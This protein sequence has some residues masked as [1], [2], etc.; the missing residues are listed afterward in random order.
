MAQSWMQSGL[1]LRPAK[2]IV[3]RAPF[4]KALEQTPNAAGITYETGV[5]GGV[6]CRPQDARK[7]AVILYLHSLA[8]LEPAPHSP[9]QAQVFYT[10]PIPGGFVVTVH[11]GAP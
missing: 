10:S 3:D 9:P 2:A 1:R 4:D 7:G 8:R 11:A 6:W 5:V